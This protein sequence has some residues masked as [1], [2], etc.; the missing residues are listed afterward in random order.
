[1]DKEYAKNE[2]TRIIN[3]YIENGD[4]KNCILQI[5]EERGISAAK[6]VIYYI[7]EHKKKELEKED[8]ITLKNIFAFYV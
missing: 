8:N 4:E 3:E 5:I 6:G 1:M 7:D 2:L